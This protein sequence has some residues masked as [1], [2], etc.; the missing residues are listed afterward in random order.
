MFG[1]AAPAF[2]ADMDFG[3]EAAL[4]TAERFGLR[5]PG[6][7]PSRMLVRPDNGA[8]HIMDSPVELSRVVTP[9]LDRCEEAGPDACLAPAI[10][11]L[12]MVGQGPY[13]SGRSRQGVPVLQALHHHKEQSSW[14]LRMYQE[15]T[16][17]GAMCIIHGCQVFSDRSSGTEVV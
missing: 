3:A 12:A 4:T 14:R 10:K 17:A 2:R 6:V 13:R 11:R 8:I 15:Y 5:A 9:L 1:T 16:A 7:G